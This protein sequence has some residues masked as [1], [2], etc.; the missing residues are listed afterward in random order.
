[1]KI[2]VIEDEPK[3]AEFLA[4][5]L[6]ENHFVVDVAHDGTTGFDLAMTGSYD[7]AIVDVMLPGMDGWSIV[8]GLRR[9]G[10]SILALFLTARD[11]VADRVKGLN[12]GADAYLV[13]PFA[14]SELLAQVRSLLRRRSAQFQSILRVAGLEIDPI[15]HRASRDGVR[16][17]LSPKEFKL[18]MLF[19]EHPDEVLSRAIIAEKV[20]DM[21]F[22][23]ETNV[24]EV[25]IRRL[26]SKVDDPFEQK[27]IRT[28]R[29]LG[30]RLSTEDFSENTSSNQQVSR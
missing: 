14:F 30:Y 20:W 16:L 13:K 15:H 19:A 6:R 9:S 5:G 25:H 7:V 23:S 2:L 22:D 10:K 12:L 18:L 26:R 28:V 29:G 1:M 3:T 21:N 4:R 17:D 11:D 8:D 24:V 27:L